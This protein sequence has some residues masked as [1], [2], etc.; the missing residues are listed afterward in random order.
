M[1]GTV[2]A[3]IKK[4]LNLYIFYERRRKNINDK[5]TNIDRNLVLTVI[6]QVVPY[7]DF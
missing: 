3:I 4:E 2:I 7:R 1:S 6:N 5:N